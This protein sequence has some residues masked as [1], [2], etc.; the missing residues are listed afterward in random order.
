MMFDLKKYHEIC[1]HGT[2]RAAAEEIL[3]VNS[4]QES[5]GENHWL[6]EGIYFF[7]KD[8]GQARDFIC[9]A[10]QVKDYSIIEAEIVSEKLLDLIDKDTFLELNG[11]CDEI[12][13]R[14]KKISGNGKTVKVKNLMTNTIALNAA[15]DIIPYEVVRAAFETPKVEKI[16]GTN[17]IPVQ[18]QVCVKKPEAIVR[19]EEMNSA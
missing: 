11:L 15:Y 9:K 3:K 6:G 16:K 7:E 12:I 14:L 17:F 2:A 1:Y 19:I 13:A 5:K 8:V 18:I 10:R 4:F